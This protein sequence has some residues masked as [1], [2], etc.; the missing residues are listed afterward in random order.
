MKIILDTANPAVAE[1]ISGW[2]E[3]GVYRM[4]VIATEGPTNGSLVE[5]DIN[6]ITDYGDAEGGAEEG[7]GR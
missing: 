5:F 3:G 6:E 7:G 4:E 1:M 2:Q